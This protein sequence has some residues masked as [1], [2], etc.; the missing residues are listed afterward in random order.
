MVI[1]E[2]GYMELQSRRFRDLRLQAMDSPVPVMATVMRSKFDFPDGL[3]ARNDTV[4]ITVRIDNRDRL[5]DEL[6]TRLQQRS[7]S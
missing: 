6:V 7:F 1:D 2:I 5:V 4:V 3:K